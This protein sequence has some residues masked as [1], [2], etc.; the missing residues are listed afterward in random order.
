MKEVSQLDANGF[1]VGLTVA[2]ESPLERGV[3]LIP[4]GAVDSLPPSF[5][6]G[7]RARFSQG[8][9]TVEDI[10]KESSQSPEPQE[11]AMPAPKQ[12]TSLE[13]LELF[14]EDEQLAVVSATMVNAQVKLWYDKMLAAG[15]ITKA[16]PRTA[17]GLDALVTSGLL[18]AGR[19][20]EIWDAL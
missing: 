20:A 7:Q 17:T 5:L 11:Q 9:W 18:T 6:E 1:F 12:F 19:R 2:D 14:S 3:Y 4:G 15:Y 13:Y 8:E 10:P 16:D